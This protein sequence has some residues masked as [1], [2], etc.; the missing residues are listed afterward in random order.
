MR[1]SPIAP[2]IRAVLDEDCWRSAGQ[3]AEEIGHPERL[4]RFAIKKLLASGEVEKRP[5]EVLRSTK[6]GM[7]VF[8]FRLRQEDH[9]PESVV[10]RA[11][12]NRHPLEQVWRV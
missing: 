2:K 10:L 11:L 3:I 5:H 7:P 12:K 1:R 9:C 8:L 4:V 6:N